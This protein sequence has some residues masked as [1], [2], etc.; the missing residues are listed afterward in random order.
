MDARRLG[1][2]RLASCARRAG[3]SSGGRRSRRAACRSPK[4]PARAGDRL[5]D[6]RQAAVN[7]VPRSRPRGRSP[8]P[9][10][11]HSRA[12]RRPATREG[13]DLRPGAMLAREWRGR[14]ERVSVL[15]DG[16]A[17]NGKTYG[18][19]SRIANAITGASWNGHRF[20]GLRSGGCAA[21]ATAFNA[22]TGS[23]HAGGKTASV[24]T[25]CIHGPPDLAPSDPAPRPS[26]RRSTSRG[27]APR[28]GPGSRYAGNDAAE[29][30][31]T[32]P[33]PPPH[34]AA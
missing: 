7:A 18:S 34:G 20:F 5:G 32:A 6:H 33:L 16:F 13:V 30:T 26:R 25:P 4:K 28:S 24:E 15:E 27:P 21:T 23:T 1:G 22:R 17:W 10:A 29:A 11:R 12:N 2:R 8:A 9:A 31:A 14:L 3:S 19:L